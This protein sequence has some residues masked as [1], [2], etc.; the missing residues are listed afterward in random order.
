M[1]R[2]QKSV[3]CFIY[4]DAKHFYRA[5]QLPKG[6]W[7][8]TSNSEMYPLRHNPKNLLESP[9]EFAT[10]KSYFSMNRSINYPLD[11]ILDGA[12]ILNSKY[13]NGKGVNQNLYYAMIEFDENG[14]KYKLSYNGK[15]DFQQKN[16]DDKTFVFSVPVI[17]DSAWGILSQNDDIQYSIDCS[18]NNPKAI[19]VLFDNFT[20]Q[21]RYTFQSVAAPI[22]KNGLDNSFVIPFVLVNQDGDSSGIVAKSQTGDSTPN[23]SVS[24][25]L[26]PNDYV[27]TSLD[28]F[29]YSFYQ[30]NNINIQGSF[31]FGW[32][33]NNLPSGGLYIFFRTSTGQSQ[34]ISP[35]ALASGGLI[36]GQI[37]NFPFN[38]NIN[39]APG[40]KFFFMA[41][42][43]DN[44]LREFTITPIVTNIFISTTTVVEPAI[45]FGLRPL[46]LLKSIVR[47]GT[48]ERYNIDSDFFAANNNTIL[49]P[50][51]SFRGVSN[52]KIYTSFKDFFDTFS[53]LFFMALRVVNGSLFMELADE[54]YK[55]DT[56]IIDLG[57][58]IECN[59]YPAVEYYPNEIEVG[60]PKQDYRHPSGRLEFN[61]PMTL[62]LPFTNIKNKLSLITK[63][64]TDPFGMIFLLLDYRGSST[65]DNSGDKSV[66]VVDITDQQGAA[67]EDVETFEN[68]TVNNAPLAPIIKYPLSGDIINN[69]KPLLKGIGI[70]GTT[71]NIY[72]ESVFDGTTVVD[73]NGNWTYQIIA[74]LPSYDPGVFDGI[75]NINATNTTMSGALDTIQL[76]IDTTVPSDT[77]IIYP[78]LNDS[79]YNNLPLIKGVAPPL[80]NI[81]I[82]LDGILLTSVVADN[83]CKF[84]FKCV[85]PI[86][87]GSH[88]LDIGSTPVTFSVDSAVTFP[89]ITYVG[90]ELDGFLIVNNLP[91]IKG[92]ALPGTVVTLWLNYISY[93]PLGSA[94]A[95]INGDWSFQVIATN[96]IDP[97]SGLPVV[98]A[99][100]RNGI[101][102]ISTLLI[103]N[104]VKINVS[105]F[106]LNR[107]AYNSITG[108]PDNTVF[109]TRLSDK[110]MLMNHKSLLSAIMEKNPNDPISYQT[111]DKNPNLRTVLGSEVVTERANIYPNSLGSPIA[112]LEYAKIKCVARKNYSETLYDFNN[113]GNIKGTFKGKDLY[114]LPIG[115]MKMKSIM[116]DIQEWNL[117]ISPL[118]T[119]FD[120]LNLHKNGLTINLMQNAVYHSDY[121]SLHFVTYNFAQPDKYN[122]KSIYDDWFD[123]RNDAWLYGKTD[124]IQKYQLTESGFKDQIITNGISSMTLRMYRC[125]DATLVTVFNY[126]AVAP[127]PI[128]IPEVVL[129]AV[130][131]LATYAISGEQYF[132]VMMIGS[133]M[134]AISE[135]I[136]VRTKWHNT[137]LIES[138][139]SL[140]MPGA[141]YST[142]WK[143]IIR[144]EGLVKK[145][146]PSIDD[147]IAKEESGDTKTIWANVSKKR[148]VRL[149][150]A[151][152]FPDYLGIKCGCALTNDLCQIEGTLYSLD[153]GEKMNPS[154]DIEGV[155]MYHYDVNMTLQDNSRGKVF[156][157]VGVSDTTGV[158]LVV[159]ASAIGLPTDVLIDITE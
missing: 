154:D 150:T 10:N 81:D 54:V 151:R 52:S 4:D 139:N 6:Y 144:V 134:V 32:S 152:G 5:T 24:G 27:I 22:I 141:F 67:L 124:Y 111:H 58:L 93:S 91:L 56:N 125:K 108:V 66:F 75:S 82:F 86:T 14:G 64:R 73:V 115:N 17:D 84:E 8:I 90:S 23:Q 127:P 42:L 140:N 132:F 2:N 13:I 96:Y 51:E 55:K 11:F 147:V 97:I 83:S 137:I 76:I 87:N 146:Q 117:L 28:Y 80:T 130:I 89:L 45:C 104:S 136:E 29:F 59:T 35:I 44:A 128:P 129:E 33:T 62:S 156:P 88:I 106:K 36:P 95:D 40:E 21:N 26:L 20:L 120:L 135:R 71:V 157:G 57:E 65:V 158:I 159:D 34:L 72:V 9:V 85:V 101:N 100:I 49:I 118:T 119:R 109:N 77:G 110:R 50:G 99:P 98:L 63:Y 148:M 19:K 105:G 145:L 25:P 102:V 30:L 153:E 31:V 60:S 94:V 15:F 78:R 123:N 18:Q 112:V 138:E 48:L 61:A 16:M 142:G 114:M 79:L 7:V 3:Y 74:S 113:G 122:F 70:P 126:N 1:N 155:P 116:D 143:T 68:V 43:N 107:P 121:N 38:F 131:D 41:Q 103:N 149:G 133:T 39:L 47:K 53:A 92:V 46:D 69:D 37:Y 12:A